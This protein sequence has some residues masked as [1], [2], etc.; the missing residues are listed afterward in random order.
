MCECSAS[1]TQGASLSLLSSTWQPPRLLSPF[2]LALCPTQ[3][4][5]VGS[6]LQGSLQEGFRKLPGDERLH[7]HTSYRAGAPHLLK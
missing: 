3:V 6:I 4:L 2:L 5:Q 7:L 1:D